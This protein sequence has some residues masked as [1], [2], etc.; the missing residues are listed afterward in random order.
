MAYFVLR[1]NADSQE[2]IQASLSDRPHLL[3]RH[4]YYLSLPNKVSPFAVLV[5][6]AQSRTI[7]LP[8]LFALLHIL[9]HLHLSLHSLP[10]QRTL[11]DPLSFL[12]DTGVPL[13]LPLTHLV[14]LL[15]PTVAPAL[16]LILQCD[17]PEIAWW[18]VAGLM[19]WLVWTVQQW[20]QQSEEDIKQLDTMRY[21]ARGA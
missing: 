8:S 4:I 16:A 20:I 19:T 7:P 3:L 5:H 1:G 12:H 17:L 15:T 10:D 13:P 14:S 9:V 18:C 2:V 21:D 6:D 11:P